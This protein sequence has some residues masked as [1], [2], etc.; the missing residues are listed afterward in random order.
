MMRYVLFMG[1]NKCHFPQFIDGLQNSVLVRNQSKMP[2]IQEDPGLQ[3][4]NL[5]LIRLSIIEKGAQFTVRELTQMT[6][7]GLASVQLF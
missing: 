3:L 4:P 6:N 5:T 2:L 1:I 7:F